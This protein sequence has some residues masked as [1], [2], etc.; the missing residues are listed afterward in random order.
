V[1]RGAPLVI[2]ADIERRVP[3]R[4]VEVID[5][6]GG[7]GSGRRGRWNGEQSTRCDGHEDQ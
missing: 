7:R 6:E 3:R 1:E 5:I 2:D 4:E